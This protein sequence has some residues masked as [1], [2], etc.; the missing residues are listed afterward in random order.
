MH[1][2]DYSDDTARIIDEEV[3]QILREQEERCRVTLTTHRN[4]LDLVARALLE[5]ETIDGSEVV[6][7][8]GVAAN[9]HGAN[10]SGTST[11]GES[12]TVPEDRLEPPN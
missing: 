7:L 10:G 3:E 4:G 9:G 8:I 2:R 12:V 1:T 5:H 11:E 6:R